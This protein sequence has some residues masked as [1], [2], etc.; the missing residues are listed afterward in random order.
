LFCALVNVNKAAERTTISN[1]ISELEIEFTANISINIEESKSVNF[2]I[3]NML[4]INNL[5]EISMTQL[6]GTDPTVCV[7]YYNALLIL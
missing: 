5:L 2:I 4:F 6:L 3:S 7:C 1:R